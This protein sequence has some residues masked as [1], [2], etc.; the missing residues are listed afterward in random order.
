[1]KVELVVS[2]KDNFCENIGP[3]TITQAFLSIDGKLFDLGRFY[4]GPHMNK[5]TSERLALLLEF[6]KQCKDL[7]T[8][9]SNLALS[10][11][12]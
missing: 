10:P 5:E 12:S 7:F 6:G 9:S 4:E 8:E 11:K 3:S 2:V 1:M